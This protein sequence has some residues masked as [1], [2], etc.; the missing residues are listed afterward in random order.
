M[1]YIDVQ[2][3][4]DSDKCP[5]CLGWGRTVTRGE[6]PHPVPCVCGRLTWPNLGVNLPAGAAVSCGGGN[7]ASILHRGERV[8]GRDNG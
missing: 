1:M 8:D 5:R 2:I 3:C 7:A 4:E 6:C